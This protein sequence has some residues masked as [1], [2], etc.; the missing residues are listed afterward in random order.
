MAL[1]LFVSQHH[2]GRCLLPHPGHTA[3]LGE[4]FGR[5]IQVQLVVVTPECSRPEPR[6]QLF[7]ILLGV[8]VLASASALQPRSRL[9][10][11]PFLRASSECG[12]LG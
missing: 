4:P 6:D 8:L 5:V 2:S 3:S 12:A 7:P 11:F 9:L 10:D 1:L